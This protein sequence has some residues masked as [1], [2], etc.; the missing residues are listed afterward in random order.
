MPLLGVYIPHFDQ[1]SVK[2]QFWGPIPLIVALALMG[3]RFSMEAKFHPI[4]ATCCP[5]GAK[6]P[7]SQPLS[8]LNNRHFALRAM[9]PV[10]N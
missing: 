1:I 2:F 8:N 7:Q 10:N 4:G 6:K 9:L 3:V 5:C